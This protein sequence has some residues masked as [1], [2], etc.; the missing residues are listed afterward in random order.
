MR[1][2]KTLKNFGMYL[3]GNTY[4]GQATEIMLPKI[5]VKVDGMLGA[6]FTEYPIFTGELS[7]LQVEFKL[8][9]FSE[10]TQKLV[11]KYPATVSLMAR[12]SLHDEVKPNE[13]VPVVA[14]LTG[15]ITQYN[16][17]A[18]VAGKNTE[19]SYTMIC[20]YYKLAVKG[21][22]VFE[23]DLNSNIYRVDGVDI[24]EQIRGLIQT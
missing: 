8:I 15:W 3:N 12:G 23:I 5:D 9:D 16:P 11:G 2:P 17:S 19:D 10:E 4:L 21:V 22:I 18:W 1:P 13:T 20:T 14:T 24:V 7:H 6:R